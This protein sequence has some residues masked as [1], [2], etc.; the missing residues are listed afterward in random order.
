MVVTRG[1]GVKRVV[2]GNGGQIYG[3]GSSDFGSW[4]TQCYM[5]MIY[6]RDACLKP[7]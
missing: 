1:K 4:G 3:D 7:I 6:G 2:K 5:E